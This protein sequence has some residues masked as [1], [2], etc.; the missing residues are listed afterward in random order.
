MTEFPRILQLDQAGNPHGWITYQD[1]AYYYAKGLV[2][3]SMGEVEFDIR[4]GTNARTMER[5]RL[6]INTIIAVKGEMSAK[7]M[8]TLNRV[9]LTNRALFRRDWNICAYC[10]ET[11]GK[12]DLTRDHVH[13]RSK[14][15]ED[16]WEN[17]VTACG[18]CNKVKDNH[19]LD[20]CGMQLIYVPY[21]PTRAEF[22]ILDN[23]RILADQMDFLIKRVPE[24]SRV[25]QLTH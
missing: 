8:A 25:H 3:W 10:G 5:S 13:P 12:E 4:G 14:G 11:F 17:V 19:T 15:G 1:S 21:A 16:R 6:T 20:Q 18:E 7:R 24:H 23:N 22:L 2:A 9:P